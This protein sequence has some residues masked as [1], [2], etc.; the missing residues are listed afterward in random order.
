MPQPVPPTSRCASR[1]AS[2]QGV[3]HHR[4]QSEVRIMVSDRCPAEPGQS[5][6][7]SYGAA[8]GCTK[9][10]GDC[11]GASR[12]GP[13]LR[14]AGA[15]RSKLGAGASSASVVSPSLGTG[16]RALR[17]TSSDG[18]GLDDLAQAG[19]RVCGRP[20]A[21]T[22][23]GLP[24]RAAA[25]LGRTPAALMAAGSPPRR[26]RRAR[27]DVRRRKAD[28]RRRVRPPVDRATSSTRDLHRTFSATNCGGAGFPHAYGWGLSKSGVQQL[29]HHSIAMR[30]RGRPEPWRRCAL[31]RAWPRRSG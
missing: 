15:G 24:G 11:A 6:M 31:S 14:I 20:L 23:R 1:S 5:A 29:R 13:S 22:A 8:T 16:A 7:F 10:D 12:P 4:A 27:Q 30:G 17:S 28:D 2:L 9:S 3:R 25:G 18:P 21:S 19:L 26:S